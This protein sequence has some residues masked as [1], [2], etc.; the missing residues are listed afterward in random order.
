VI[1]V[2]GHLK[3]SSELIKYAEQ[4]V[5]LPRREF[6]PPNSLRGHVSN[7][8]AFIF[9]G[10]LVVSLL[11]EFRNAFPIRTAVNIVEINLADNL[12][13]FRVRA[14]FLVAGIKQQLHIRF[15]DAARPAHQSVDIGPVLPQ[16]LL[17]S[18]AR[19]HDFSGVRGRK[20]HEQK[21]LRPIGWHC[22]LPRSFVFRSERGTG[23][24]MKHR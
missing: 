24:R 22:E 16:V 5:L 3:L 17:Q 15:R 6:T 9:F 13:G 21:L 14:T 12:F 23:Q 4:P 20:H 7:K 11:T 1:V 18:L 8:R 2:G 19:S 10:E